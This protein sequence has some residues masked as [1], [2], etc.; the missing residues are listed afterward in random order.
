[1]KYIVW[2]SCLFLF[3]CKSD[4]DAILTNKWL[5][6]SYVANSG[7]TVTLQPSPLYFTFS[8]E[9]TITVD[10]DVNSC[11]GQYTKDKDDLELSGFSC[12]EICCD[13][14]SSLNVYQLFVDSVK[15]HDINGKTLKLSGYYGTALQLSLVE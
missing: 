3:A 14:T 15:T 1:M 12:T 2:L 7:S 8:K 11:T 4:D 9:G 10:L 5:L 6:T 13:S